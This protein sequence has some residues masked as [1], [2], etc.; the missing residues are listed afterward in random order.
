MTLTAANDLKFQSTYS[1]NQQESPDISHSR[2]LLEKMSKNWHKRAQSARVR[3]K[4]AT[5]SQPD[6][7]F[8]IECDDFRVDLLPFK[9]HPAFLNA[10]PAMQKNIL[11]CGWI[12]YN[13]KTVDIESRVIGPACNHIIYKE[14]PGVEDGTS[15]MI[16]SD[17]LVDEAYHIQLVV[18]A[19]RLTRHYRNLEHLRLPSFQLVK[20]MEQEKALYPESWQKILVQTATAIVSEVFVSDYLKL[21]AHDKQIQPL[22]RLTVHTHLRDENAH[23]SIFKNLA[24]C[25]YAYLSPEQQS[26]FADILPKPVRWFA[27]IELEVWEEILQQINFP[28]A[29]Q[30]IQDCTSMTD[31]NLLRIDYSGINSLAE[32]LGILNSARGVESF[33]KAGLLN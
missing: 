30:M 13:E 31:V 28:K 20:K 7:A 15:Q 17:T 18:A 12:A 33:T 6:M 24:R 21:L 32:E 29:K 1:A 19:C 5:V 14:L 27:N 16:A 22:N 11:S 3:E 10:S 23:H 8:D 26:F 4:V 9:D 2:I 25:I